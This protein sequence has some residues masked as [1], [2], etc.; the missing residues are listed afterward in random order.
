VQT[1]ALTTPSPKPALQ[2]EVNTTSTHDAAVP[3]TPATGAALSQSRAVKLPRIHQSKTTDSLLG[4]LNIQRT[5][6]GKET[7]TSG[8]PARTGAVEPHL[9]LCRKGCASDPSLMNRDM[10]GSTLML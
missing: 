2:L 5:N 7:F 9:Q 4:R 8:S 1:N 3:P 10:A 6:S